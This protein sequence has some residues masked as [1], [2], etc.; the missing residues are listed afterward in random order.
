MNLASRSARLLAQIV[1]SIVAVLPVAG[2][3]LVIFLSPR[4]FEVAVGIFGVPVLFFSVGYLLFA[5]AMPG[6]Q[7]CGKR[8]L[9]IAV[10]DRR[11]GLP[12][13]RWQSF[14]RNL[15]LSLLVFLDWIFIL[16]D[17]RRRLGDIVAGTVVVEAAPIGAAYFG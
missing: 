16:G 4:H 13:T 3:L 7:S 14:V 12:C 8:M 5:D 11:T 1:D 9:G 17:R 15:L 6:G 2:L 10:V